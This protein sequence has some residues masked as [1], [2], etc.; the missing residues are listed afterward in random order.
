MKF[1]GNLVHFHN[2]IAGG[3]YRHYRPAVDRDAGPSDRRQQC[4]I[5]VIQPLAGVQDHLARRRLAAL[6]ID[7][8][9][10]FGR[11]VDRHASTVAPRVLDHHDGVR[12]GRN[13]R[14]GHDLHG[15]PFGELSGETLARAHFPDNL[16]LSR[17]I[18]GAHRVAVAHRSRNRGRIAVR[19]GVRREH[20]PG[21]IRKGNLLDR[22][23]GAPLAHSAENGFASIHKR[24]RRHASIIALRG[25][26]AG[27]LVL[28]ELRA[29]DEVVGA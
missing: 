2:F 21:G 22:G 16:E 1:L 3:D 23:L 7:E 10:R 17:Q 8:L 6:W 25:S 14:A 19:G 5:G 11:A 20:A 9:V 27:R 18:D 26:R 28:R 12:A 29:I 24:Q 13:G 15:L 4:D